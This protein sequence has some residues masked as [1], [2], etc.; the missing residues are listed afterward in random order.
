MITDYVHVLPQHC[1]NTSV[2]AIATAPIT[3]N[4][5]P[6]HSDNKLMYIF[7]GI[8]WTVLCEFDTN[9]NVMDLEMSIFVYDPSCHTSVMQVLC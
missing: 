3:M 5:R 1:G 7:F 2:E 9:R 4:K 6:D 8:V